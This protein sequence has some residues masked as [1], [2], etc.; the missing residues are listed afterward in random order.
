[1]WR[2][3]LEPLP[4]RENIVLETDEGGRSIFSAPNALPAGTVMDVSPCVKISVNVADQ[5]FLWDAV[6]IATG[7]TVCACE[8]AEVCW[9]PSI[10]TRT[11]IR[12][13][14]PA[15]MHSSVIRRAHPDHTR[16]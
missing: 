7:K 14:N 4:C 6:L 13:S 16:S 12:V 9:Q 15:G 2:P 11:N 1:M 3:E 8:D 10:L 5:F